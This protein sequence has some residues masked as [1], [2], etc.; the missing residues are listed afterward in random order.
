TAD[1]W[2]KEIPGKM[3]EDAQKNIF[4]NQPQTE[5]GVHDIASKQ[6]EQVKTVHDKLKET[7]DT[8][9]SQALEGASTARTQALS[10]IDSIAASTC[11]SLAAQSAAQVAAVHQQASAARAGI[12]QAG[13]A[14]QASLAQSCDKSAA[15]LESGAVGLVKGAKH[16][17][18]RN[19]GDAQ[20]AVKQGEAQLKQGA[21]SIIDGLRKSASQSAHGM[22]A[23]AQS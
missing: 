23:Q 2:A 13:K 20:N 10:Q 12:A 3:Q 7:L 19:P 11:A 9:H 21:H 17:E 4:G 1:G 16:V 18:A 6:K 22:T 5:S 8:A 15:G 14:A